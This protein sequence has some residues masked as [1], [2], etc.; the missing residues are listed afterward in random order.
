MV[1][2]HWSMAVGRYPGL[3]SLVDRCCCWSMVVVV[4][5]RLSL[6]MVVVDGRCRCSMIVGCRSLV[7]DR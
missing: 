2:G 6:S 7:D 5:D 4:N 3:L 1:I